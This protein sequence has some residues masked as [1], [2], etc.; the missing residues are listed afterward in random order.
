MLPHYHVKPI[1]KS[2]EIISHFHSGMSKDYNSPARCWCNVGQH[3]LIIQPNSISS[4]Y[5]GHL[6]KLVTP[7]HSFVDKQLNRLS[8]GFN[9]Q[10]IDSYP[11]S[12]SYLLSNPT[13]KKYFWPLLMTLHFPPTWFYV[14]EFVLFDFLLAFLYDTCHWPNLISFY[15][16]TWSIF[17]T[18]TLLNFFS[19]NIFYGHSLTRHLVIL[20]DSSLHMITSSSVFLYF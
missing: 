9:H 10:V 14:V 5:L 17:T 20:A 6:C 19:R 13:I 3:P 15:L 7:Y 4:Y 2:I 18:F 12:L 8:S 16:L 1:I 11:F